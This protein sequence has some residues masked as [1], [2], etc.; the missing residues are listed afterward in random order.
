MSHHS[1]LD[2]RM[3]HAHAL[4]VAAAEALSR[5]ADAIEDLRGPRPGPSRRAGPAGAARHGVPAHPHE[6]STDGR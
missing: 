1:Q 4:A 3:E 2:A 6:A 5:L